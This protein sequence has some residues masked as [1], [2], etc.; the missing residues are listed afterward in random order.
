MIRGTRHRILARRQQ[1]AADSGR[2]IRK[3]LG[4]FRR[5]SVQPPQNRGF[6]GNLNVR[7]QAIHLRRRQHQLLDDDNL[8]VGK[9]AR[10][11][12]D[13]LPSGAFD[14]RRPA[15]EPPRC[16]RTKDFRICLP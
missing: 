4:R 14:A 1:C 3:F 2:Q 15:M 9:A 12:T 8:S 6:Q 7:E 13:P 5:D 11:I 10:A 16:G